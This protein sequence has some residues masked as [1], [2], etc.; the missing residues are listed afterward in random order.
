MY[1]IAVWRR[2]TTYAGGYKA[3][4]PAVLLFW[5]V[6][7]SWGAEQ[8]AQWVRFCWGRSRLPQG[9]RWPSN[10]RMRLRRRPGEPG[11]V[12]NA[13]T[14]F[15]ECELPAY[16]TEDEMRQGLEICINFGLAGILEA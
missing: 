5:K 14:C 13:H 1:D 10:E 15:F 4:D 3:E 6:L 11:A 9:A 2:N 16:E 8:R 7:E 12:P